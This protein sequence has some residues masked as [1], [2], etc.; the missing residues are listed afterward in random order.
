[1]KNRIKGSLWIQAMVTLVMMLMTWGCKPK[2]VFLD[3]TRLALLEND[4]ELRSVQVYNDKAI[5]LRRAASSSEVSQTG[6][7]LVMVDGEQVLEVVIPARTKGVI[8]GSQNGK[9]L[10]RFEVG[11]GKI[12]QFY[13]NQKNA[14]QIEADRWVG[15]VGSL[16]YAGLDFKLKEDSN[17]V[18]LMISQRI[19]LRSTTNVRTLKGL[20]VPKAK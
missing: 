5:V 2:E 16:K 7:K 17:D 11:E 4:V 12:L 8:T 19:R 13:K 15:P 18:L 10:V 1:M 14:F 9:F 6:G 20:R 3:K